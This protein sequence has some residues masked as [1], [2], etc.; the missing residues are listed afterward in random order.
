MGQKPII[1]VPHDEAVHRFIV[2]TQ[3]A[4]VTVEVNILQENGSGS[5]DDCDPSE[6]DGDDASCDG[7]GHDYGA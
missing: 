7:Y 6:D 1:V 5:Y 4:S 3:E 2:A